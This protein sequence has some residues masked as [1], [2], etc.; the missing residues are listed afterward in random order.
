MFS[1]ISPPLHHVRIDRKRRIRE[2]MEV[3]L[4]AKRKRICSEKDGE[5]EVGGCNRESWTKTVSTL[6]PTRGRSLKSS[7]SGSPSLPCRFIVNL[8]AAF[9]DRDYL[10][11]VMKLYKAA[12]LRYHLCQYK[13]TF[14]ESQISTTTSRRVH[15][16]EHPSII[17]VHPLEECDPPWHQ[18]REPGIRYG[19]LH[20]RHRFRHFSPPTREQFYRYQWDPRLHVAWSHVPNRPHLRVWLLRSGYHHVRVRCGNGRRRSK[21]RPYKGKDRQEIRDALKTSQMVLGHDDI[22]FQISEEYIDLCNKLILRDP[23][24]RLGCRGVDEIKEHPFFDNFSWEGLEEM[25]TIPPYKP[26]VSEGWE[27]RCPKTSMSW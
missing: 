14:T 17:G 15:N 1:D 8:E 23:T 9:Q 18:T 2:S 22:P 10:Y 11:L 24:V 27:F 25:V 6:S 4:Q 5:T 7:T 13:L 12:D 16:S 19:W 21:Q 3:H 20:L 26:R